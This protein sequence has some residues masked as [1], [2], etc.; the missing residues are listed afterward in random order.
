MPSPSPRTHPTSS[1][2]RISASAIPTT[3]RPTRCWRS[4][5]PPCR[6]AGSLTDNGI[7]VTAGQFVSASDIAAGKLIFTPAANANGGN[8]ASLTFQVQD[9][10]GTANGADLDPTPRTLTLNVTA[11]NDAPVLSETTS[12]GPTVL[13]RG[14]AAVINS[15][16]TASD[17]E[18]DALNG[19]TGNYAGA[20]L[21]VVRHGGASAQDTLGFEPTGASF[22][23]S[24]GNLQAGGQTFATV[25]S[26]G[27][28]LTVNFTSSGTAATTALASDVLEHVTYSNTSHAPPANVQV[29]FILNDG[30]TGAQ[31][32][33]GA[34]SVTASTTVTI[35]PVND[36]PSGADKAVT[37]L[38]DTA[39]TFSASDFGF[40]DVDGNSLQ[41]VKIDTLPAGGTLKNNGITV[42]A[43]QLVSAFDISVGRLTYAPAANA[44]GNGAASFTF[45]VQDDGGTA[46]G[47]IDTDP[48]PNTI[49]FNITPVNDPPSG[50]DKT[51]TINEDSSYTFAA[52]DFGFSDSDGNSLQ[53]VKIAILPSAGALKDNNV[54]VTAGQAIPL[55]DITGNKLVFAP[56]AN[57]NGNGYATFTF[58]VQDNGG[59]VNGGVDTDLTPNTITVN[60]T[61]VNDAPVGTADSYSVNENSILTVPAAPGVLANDTDVDGDTL[62]VNAA[63]TVNPS[64]GALTLNSDGSF[65]Y[66][67]NTGYSGSDS[68]SYKASDGTALSGATTVNLTVSPLT[69]SGGVLWF[70]SSN[71]L[72]PVV[73]HA[74]SDGSSPVDSL[75]FAG[76]GIVQVVVDPTAGYYFVVDT[77]SGVNPIGTPQHRSYSGQHHRLPHQ[78]QY[79]GLHGQD[80]RRYRPGRNRRAGHRSGQPC[81]L[82]RQ[83]GCRSRP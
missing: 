24:G 25:T 49:T 3:V 58:Q 72:V 74:N 12:T 20:S 51:V 44:N 35:T 71:G 69:S 13:E 23:V 30:N 78:R 1:A 79:P 8:Y 33:G 39:Y 83:M 52:A 37:T 22:T 38:E 14:P 7:A 68:F 36:A 56:T 57:A 43:G 48:T 66:T 17:I 64:H 2:V 19:G 67:P 46:N 4:K 47:G 54:A 62:T 26:S 11:V 50:T 28:T 34:K 18:L 81:P 27:G 21:T 60:V 41:A 82:R 70:T 76:K 61:P 6:A 45:Q 31:G 65:T 42:I 73:G 5:S 53:A 75:N 77:A 59:T 10:G 40:S 9:N 15:T 32:T 16:L 29:D 80:R 55:A 63:S